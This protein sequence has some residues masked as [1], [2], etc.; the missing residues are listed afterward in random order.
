MNQREAALATGQSQTSLS[1]IERGEVAAPLDV[2]LRMQWAYG[3]DSLETLFGPSP[4][5]RLFADA[6]ADGGSP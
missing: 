2:L 5:A 4:S 6:C 3:I 1:R